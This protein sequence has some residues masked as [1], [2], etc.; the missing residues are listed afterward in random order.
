MPIVLSL[1]LHLTSAHKSSAFSLAKNGVK[2]PV[3]RLA[4]P[5]HEILLDLTAPDL[6]VPSISDDVQQ[7]VI[8][9]ALLPAR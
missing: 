1:S 3:F 4:P 8:C 5:G 7:Q 9:Q 6:S 2:K